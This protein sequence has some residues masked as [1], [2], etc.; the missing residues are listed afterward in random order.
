MYI[1]DGGL[2]YSLVVSIKPIFSVCSG[3]IYVLH[4]W[5]QEVGDSFTGTVVVLKVEG[6]TYKKLA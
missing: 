1:H 5:I 2:P 3:K 6:A 4:S